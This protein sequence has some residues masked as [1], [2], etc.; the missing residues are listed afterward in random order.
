MQEELFR[1]R[2][3]HIL[4]KP[5]VTFNK[6]TMDYTAKMKF[7]GTQITDTLKWHSHIQLL[8]SKLSEVAFMIKYGS[9]YGKVPQRDSEPEFDSKHLFYKIS[10]TS[11]VWNIILGGGG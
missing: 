8:A 11:P 2:Q 5:R 1:N 4:V 6:T 9:L 10:L 3:S 7:L